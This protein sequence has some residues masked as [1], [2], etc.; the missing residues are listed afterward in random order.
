MQLDVSAAGCLLVGYAADGLYTAQ[1]YNGSIYEDTEC[2]SISD[3]EYR[4][5]RLTGKSE[6]GHVTYV[7]SNRSFIVSTDIH[8]E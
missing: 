8:S 1:Q 4:I 5:T 3:K 7:F 2:S 6:S